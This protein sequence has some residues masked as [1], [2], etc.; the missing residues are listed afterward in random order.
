M[1]TSLLKAPRNVLNA[2]NRDLD[3][4]FKGKPVLRIV[5]LDIIRKMRICVLPVMKIAEAAL[6]LIVTSVRSNTKYYFY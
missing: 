1:N 3:G 4:K 6:D 2:W 5:R